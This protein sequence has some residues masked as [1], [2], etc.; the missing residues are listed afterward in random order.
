MNAAYSPDPAEHLY[1]GSYDAIHRQVWRGDASAPALELTSAEHE[2]FRAIVSEHTGLDYPK[3]KREQLARALAQIMPAAECSTLEELYAVLQRAASTSALWDELVGALTIGETYFFRNTNHFDALEKSILPELLAAREHSNRR[4]RLWSAGC[5]TGE[6]PYSLAILIRELV[7]QPESWNISILATDINRE[8]LT[9]ARRAVYSAWSFRGVAPAIQEKYFHAVGDKQF[10]LDEAVKG[11]VTFDYLNLVSD[12]YPSLINNTNALDLILCRNV[13]IYFSETVTR[14]VLQRFYQCLLEGGWL[15]PGPSEP[16][17]LFYGAFEA[18]NFPGAVIYRK[19]PAQSP[20]LTS[21]AIIAPPPGK[22]GN[23]PDL[24]PCPS[25]FTEFRTGTTK[26][27]G[28]TKTP[29]LAKPLPVADATPATPPPDAYAAAV[30][31]LEAGRVEEALTQ[32]YRK[33]DQD[34]ACAPAYALIGRIYANQGKLEDAQH[35]CERALQ[36]DKLHPGPYFTLSL[37]YQENGMADSAIDALKHA[38][39][40]DRDFVMAHYNLALLYVQQHERELAVKTLQNVDR[41]VQSKPRTDLIPEGD[42]L[43]VGRLREL[44]AIHLTQD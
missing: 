40:L 3:D 11:M 30:A 2:K 21:P 8:L 29:P 12:A 22:S 36:V 37:V 27:G 13:T 4:L 1:D 16:N 33:L 6:E 20:A 39:Y 34:A 9:R 15:I 23:A 25:S 14:A 43:N 19:S 32:L 18:R 42:G 7:P 28:V 41:L 31:Q 26:R 44:V 17:L 24:T 5:A 10:A 35:W 38:I